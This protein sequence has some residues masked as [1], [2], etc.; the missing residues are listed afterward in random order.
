[1]L[2]GG[3]CFAAGALFF[4]YA[5]VLYAWAAAAPLSAAPRIARHAAATAVAVT[6]QVGIVASCVV[7]AGAV[8]VLVFLLAFGA[9]DLIIG[10]YQRVCSELPRLGPLP[11]PQGATKW[12]VKGY[13]DE[14]IESLCKTQREQGQAAGS[15]ETDEALCK[16]THGGERPACRACD[17]APAAR[18][19]LAGEWWG[20]EKVTA[21]DCVGRCVE[22]HDT[23]SNRERGECGRGELVGVCSDDNHPADPDR[24]CAVVLF[25]DGQRRRFP[26]TG[27]HKG[28]PAWHTWLSLSPG[29]PGERLLTIVRGRLL[30]TLS[31]KL[32]EVCATIGA[33]LLLQDFLIWGLQV[34]HGAAPADAVTECFDARNA[35]A[36]GRCMRAQLS[37]T[38]LSAEQRFQHA[39]TWSGLAL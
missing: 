20:G 33:M 17:D 2:V 29:T 10:V 16:G 39:L 8:Y 31:P 38:T 5:P 36:Y 23:P 11:P 19:P 9:R 4:A 6:A 24:N 7:I 14:I 30:P 12:A 34:V 32:I 37:N 15:G 18:D 13:E 3:V 35:D 25:T 1:M 28:T 21:E 22:V 27:G 26:F